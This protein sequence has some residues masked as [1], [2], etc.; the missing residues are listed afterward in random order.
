MAKIVTLTFNPCIDKS[1]SVDAVV[2]E[3]KL[4]CTQPKFDPGGGGINVAR[5]VKKLGGE[6]LAIYPA[7]GYSG[8][9][10]NVLV[11][12]EGVE[13]KVIE[14][15]SHTRENM[16]VLDESANVQFRFG[17]PGSLL[18]PEECN[19]LLN[20]L[21]EIEDAAFIVASGSLSPGVP[22]DIFQQVAAIAKRKNIKF[23]ADTSGESLKCAVK[24]GVYLL[25]PNVGELS[26]LAGTGQLTSLQAID[27]AKSLIKKYGCHVVVVSMGA[28]G[29]LMVTIDEV[30]KM[31]APEV[32]KLSTVGA[33]DSMVAGI[34]FSLAN[35]KSIKDSVQFGVACG[36]AAT[37]N[38]GTE[39]CR[40]EDAQKLF[41]MVQT[42]NM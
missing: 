18:I 42:E 41:E 40:L 37:M 15:K 16:I 30:V 10:L 28:E 33:G 12:N 26:S 8:K 17:M 27:A 21:E 24:E 19:A 34:V 23:V 32:E 9:F 39:L 4:R 38:E 1:T 20:A 29:A 7:G 3:K 25:K 31:L 5:A 2:P 11:G 36:T 13:T 6:S 35:G 22:V 14:T